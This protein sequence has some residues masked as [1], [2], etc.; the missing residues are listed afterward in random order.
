[1]NSKRLKWRAVVAG[2]IAACSGLLS[3]A[4]TVFADFEGDAYPAGWTTTGTAFGTGPAMG[5]LPGQMKVTRFW[6]R[7]LVNS[8]LGGDCATG[9]LTSPE[10]KIERAFISFLVGGGASAGK[11]GIDLI[12]DGEVVRS[13]TGRNPPNSGAGVGEALAPVHWNVSDLLGRTA[14]FRIY[15]QLSCGWGHINVDHICFADEPVVFLRQATRSLDVTEDWILFPVRNGYAKTKLTVR[16]G[17]TD[18]P[19]KDIQLCPAA[20]ADWWALWNVRHLRGRRL[21]FSIEVEACSPERETVLGAIRLAD[22]PPPAPSLAADPHRPQFHYSQRLGWGNDSNGLVYR[23]GE[24]HF[25]H[26]HNPYG[27]DWGNMHWNH[28]V[29]RDL[30][31]WTELGT[32]LEPDS[33]GTMFS[34]CGVVD[35]A[36]TAG[37]G[38]NALVFAYTAAGKPFT[39]CLAYSRDG[40]TLEKFAGNPVLW[41]ISPGDRDPKIFWHAPSKAWVLILYGTEANHHVFR[42]FRSQ[43]LKDWTHASTLVGD[44]CGK[45]NWRYEC[46]GLEEL[47]IE[48]E[49]GTAWVVWGAGPWYDVGTF[50]G[51]EFKPL[52]LRNSSVQDGSNVYYAAQTFSSAPDGRSVWIAWF[53]QPVDVANTYSQTYSI[54]FDLSLRRTKD[55]LLRLVRRPVRELEALRKGPAVPLEKFEGELVEAHLACTL[56]KDG[57]ATFDLRGV[58]LVYYAGVSMLEI[59]GKRVFWPITEGCLALRVFLDR[60]SIEVLSQDGL[61]VQPMAVCPDTTLRHLSADFS[62]GVIPGECVAYELKSIHK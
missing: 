49:T 28:A 41:N 11:L 25:F 15:D 61:N 24:W 3:A 48:G 51:F 46:P 10:F 14:R 17:D 6:G 33:L 2:A 21:V 44:V 38:T 30:V 42:I 57:T 22:S 55:G 58:K 40:R 7:G 32:A 59:N 8:Y 26:Q 45:G 54:P 50:D 27:I 36:N 16:D 47:R 35:H 13:A 29:S 37:F 43:N 5:T 18:L 39:Q 53:Q 19:A 34:G 62:K 31:H 23:D 4:T 20:E 1:M 56:P 60:T 52:V 12:V 9:T